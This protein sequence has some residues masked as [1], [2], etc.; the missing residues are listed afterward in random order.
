M[1]EFL[2]EMAEI[3]EEDSVA[4]TDELDGFESWDSLA[5]LSVIAMADS[6][7]GVN[8]TAQELKPATTVGELYEIIVAK[9]AA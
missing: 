7:F 2:T 9:K 3:L 4:A 5:T 1:E 8:V 6:Q